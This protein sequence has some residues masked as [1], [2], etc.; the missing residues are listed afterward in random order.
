MNDLSVLSGILRIIPQQFG[1]N[2]EQT[3]AERKEVLGETTQMIYRTLQDL[4]KML[5][6]FPELTSGEGLSVWNRLQWARMQG[7]VTEYHG[8][9]TRHL[10]ML[11]VCLSAFTRQVL[12]LN[13]IHYCTNNKLGDL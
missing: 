4:E 5:K 6:R 8:K 3:E 11:N 13:V 9:L 7:D 12:A 2:F 1:G 10:L